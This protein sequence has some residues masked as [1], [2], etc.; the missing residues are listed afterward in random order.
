MNTSRKQSALKLKQRIVERASSR[1]DNGAAMQAEDVAA[2]HEA[3]VAAFKA[4]IQEG[5]LSSRKAYYLLHVGRLL[6]RAIITRADV[7]EA[8]W[9]R[10]AIAAPAMNR[11]NAARLLR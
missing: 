6:R 3:D 1:S 2:L 10:I 7:E 5:H 11:R 9:T 8:G 4:I